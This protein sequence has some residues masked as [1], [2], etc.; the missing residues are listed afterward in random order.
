VLFRSPFYTFLI[1]PAGDWTL[2]ADFVQEELPKLVLL[3]NNQ[4]ILIGWKTDILTDSTGTSLLV[5]Y[6]KDLKLNQSFTIQ[7]GL[8]GAS[9]KVP[10]LVPQEYWPGYPALTQTLQ[11]ADRAI[12]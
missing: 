9:S 6:P 7:F 1:R 10:L 2:D 11:S 12:A 5:G 4:T 3:Q 8:D